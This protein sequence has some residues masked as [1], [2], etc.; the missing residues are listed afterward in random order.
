VQQDPN[1]GRHE[2]ETTAYHRAED[3]SRMERVPVG[4]MSESDERTWSM[5][6]HLS[7]L[8]NL[9]SGIGGPVAAFIIW[10]VYRDRSE[11]VAFHALQSMWYQVAWIGIIAA[12]GVLS[13]VLSLVVVGIFMLLLLPVIALIPVVH[14]VYAAIK[15]NGGTNYRY[16]IIADMIDANR[17]FA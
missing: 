10:L 8:V 15:V 14:Q 3:E 9:A 16:P 1:Y 7:T 13:L 12:Y 6:A 4:G 2:E 5:L 17:R 11:R